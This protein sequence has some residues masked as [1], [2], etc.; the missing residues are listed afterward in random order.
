MSRE[1]VAE[2]PFGHTVQVLWDVSRGEE[3]GIGSDLLIRCSLPLLERL[4][5]SPRLEYFLKKTTKGVSK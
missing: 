3:G 2:G 5:F 1:A 4:V